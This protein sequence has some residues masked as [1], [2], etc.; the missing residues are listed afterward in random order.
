MEA[1]R[2][3]VADVADVGPDAIALRLE[4]P[5]GF[6]ARPGQF[7]KLEISVEG[8]PASRFYTISSATV[9]ETFEL[10]VG[11]DPDGDVSPHLRTVE[12]GATV[13]LSGPYGNAYYADESSVLLLAGGPGIG[14][15]IGVAERALADGAAVALV[16]HDDAPI[17][18]DRLAALASDASVRIVDDEADLTTAVS[19]V[20]A[21][22]QQAFLYGFADFLDAAIDAL[23][24]AG[25]SAAMAKIENYG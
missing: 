20:Y 18:A 24:A 4:S 21:A 17:H 25:G 7:V 5:A 10:T 14:A 19:D 16:Y 9:D 12:P 23:E 15:A 6:E 1:T 8:E 22:D 13:T 2:V 3:T 11:I